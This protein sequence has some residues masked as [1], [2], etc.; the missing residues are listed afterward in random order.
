MIFIS[1]SDREQSSAS[2]LKKFLTEAID[3]APE[4]ILD[5]CANNPSPPGGEKTFDRL[6]ADS[7]RRWVT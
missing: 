1:H 6:K 5:A 7:C 4:K 3:I 2:A